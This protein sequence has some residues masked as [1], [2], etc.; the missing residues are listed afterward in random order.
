MCDIQYADCSPICKINKQ[1]YSG[2]KNFVYTAYEIFLL[3]F[4][5]LFFKKPSKRFEDAGWLENF[6]NLKFIVLRTVSQGNPRRRTEQ[7]KILF[8]YCRSMFMLFQRLTSRGKIYWGSNEKSLLGSG[9]QA[10]KHLEIFYPLQSLFSDKHG[11]ARKKLIYWL[12]PLQIL[13]V[14]QPFSAVSDLCSACQWVEVCLPRD[15]MKIL[16]S[17][18]REKQ[19]PNLHSSVGIFAETF[20]SSSPARFGSLH[21]VI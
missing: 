16:C 8:S 10:G 14:S 1:K 4:L 17:F 18:Y 13:Y 5:R 20:L 12:R 21:G 9:V 19:I 11:S 3:A 2:E 6:V 7:E 15:D